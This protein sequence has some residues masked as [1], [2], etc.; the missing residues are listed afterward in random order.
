MV[1]VNELL[2]DAQMQ[3]KAF[4]GGR[5]KTAKLYTELLSNLTDSKSKV[6]LQQL[7]K[8]ARVVETDKHTKADLMKMVKVNYNHFQNRDRVNQLMVESG[9]DVASFKPLSEVVVP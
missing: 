8:D 7:L 4:S 2:K 9:L 5:L 1:E 6:N 3:V